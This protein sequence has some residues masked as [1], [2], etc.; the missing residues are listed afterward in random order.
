MSKRLFKSESKF[1]EKSR[2]AITNAESNPLIKAALADYGL[3]EEQMVH[4]RQLYNSTQNMWDTNIKEDAEST[5]AS[6]AYSTTYNKLQTLFKVHRDKTL[7]FF[8][9]KPELLAK[10]GVK[11][12]F[13]RKYN[14]FFDKVRQYYTTIKSDAAIQAELDKIKVT[15]DIVDECLVLLE[16]L[17]AKRSH[18]DKELAESQD[19]TK[20]K[21]AALL[22]LKEWMDE[23]YIIAKVALYDQ[24]QLLEALGV[25]VRS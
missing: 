16:E 22:A 14:D 19:M 7:I 3:G 17:L 11:G 1:L 12:S 20:S 9:L 13:P 24:P 10:L 4:G 23:F 18:F 6:L 5:E 21:N 2:T 15:A 25:F 8:K